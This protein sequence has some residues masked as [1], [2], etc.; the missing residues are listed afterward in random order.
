MNEELDE[1]NNSA[2]SLIS[3]LNGIQTHVENFSF[4]VYPNPANSQITVATENSSI[5]VEQVVFTD[6]LGQVVYSGGMDR[7]TP[8]RATIDVSSWTRGCYQI[9]LRTE[10][11]YY[12]KLIILH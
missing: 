7:N 12:H 10:K 9:S 1:F 6:M 8:L 3:I 2:S 11:H 5:P 4:T